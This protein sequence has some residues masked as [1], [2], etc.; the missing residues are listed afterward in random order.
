MLSRL[1]DHV[2]IST[3]NRISGTVLERTDGGVNS[4]IALNVGDGK[5]L[6]S[7]ITRLSAEEMGLKAGERVSAFFN[8]S[9]VILAVD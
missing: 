3:P 5:T 8:T 2:R 6:I 4:E 9:Q 7:V 1:D